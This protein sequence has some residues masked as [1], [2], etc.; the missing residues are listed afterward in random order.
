MC[1]NASVKIKKINDFRLNSKYLRIAINPI[2]QDFMALS[3]GK[4]QLAILDFFKKIPKMIEAHSKNVEN[5][6]FSSCGKFPVTGS[7]DNT[8]KIFEISPLKELKC[9]SDHSDEVTDV[10][11]RNSIFVSSSRDKTINIYK[12]SSL[13]KINSINHNQKIE[14]LSL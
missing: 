9:F 11:C 13:T 10:C 14:R 3:D 4:G 7:L 5:I 6:M 2:K 12:L 1:Q 8:V